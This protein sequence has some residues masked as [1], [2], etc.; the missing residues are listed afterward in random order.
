MLMYFQD[1]NSHLGLKSHDLNNDMA[2]NPP[3]SH[4]KDPAG[5]SHLR[6]MI[7]QMFY[8]EK[9]SR[10][11]RNRKGILKKVALLKYY[12]ALPNFRWKLA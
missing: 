6:H 3:P 10:D 7:L 1:G 9:D 5:F 8:F 11:H 4:K 12:P 2:P